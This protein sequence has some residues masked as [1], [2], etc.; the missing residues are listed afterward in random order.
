MEIAALPPD[1]LVFGGHEARGFPPAFA[2][3]RPPG[4]PFL[5]L[6][7]SLL[8]PPRVA[9]VLRYLAIR[10]HLEARQ[11][12]INAG[13]FAR[14]REGLG[15]H[16]RTGEGHLP[17]IRFLGD[18]DGLDAALPWAGPAHGNPPDLGQDQ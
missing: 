5:R 15:G 7:P 1:L 4:E 3:L 6:G 9:R 18:R 13:L 16:L 11:P 10:R 14:E 8:S 17:A 12:D 2:P